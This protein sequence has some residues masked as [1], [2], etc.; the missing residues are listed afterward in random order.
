MGRL[1]TSLA[2]V[3]SSAAARVHVDV[4]ASPVAS[5]AISCLGLPSGREASPATSWTETTEI[6]RAGCGRSSNKTGGDD[7]MDGRGCASNRAL[8]AARGAKLCQ[9]LWASATDSFAK[10]DI[11]SAFNLHA[12]AR[13]L[14]LVN[15]AAVAP[16]PS[17]QRQLW[18]SRRLGASPRVWAAPIH[19]R[20]E[21][22]QAASARSL[23][24]RGHVEWYPHLSFSFAETFCTPIATRASGSSKCPCR[25]STPPEPLP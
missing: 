20:V 7:G 24:I 10:H 21:T 5:S 22:T 25:T 8:R 11:T 9:R 12:R 23:T 1:L 19:S 18:V 13:M 14:H 16:Q 15:K 3:A 17:C 6:P 2:Q 4:D